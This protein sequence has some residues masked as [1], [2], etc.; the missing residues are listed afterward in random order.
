MNPIS[1]LS[2]PF[3][4]SGS[5][6]P[7]YGMWYRP[8]TPTMT[9]AKT[10]YV[11]PVMYDQFSIEMNRITRTRQNESL[12]RSWVGRPK[13]GLFVGV[14]LTLFAAGYHTNSHRGSILIHNY[15]LFRKNN[16]I[17]HIYNVD[18]FCRANRLKEK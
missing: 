12:S 9:G 13:F 10:Y 8:Y 11:R 2:N 6:M 14:R 7:S 4:C 3:S 17:I 1:C 15:E 18:V 16:L 5:R